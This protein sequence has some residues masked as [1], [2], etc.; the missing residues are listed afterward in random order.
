MEFFQ[1][2]PDKH[3]LTDG[4]HTARVGRTELTHEFFARGQRGAEVAAEA[5]SPDFQRT[6]PF[7]ER[8]LEVRPMA[9]VSPTLFMEVVSSSLAPGNFSK[10]KRGI[11]TTQ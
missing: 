9:M 8:F 4:E 2:E 6:Q 11:L 1:R 3:S 7:L 5:D 10:V